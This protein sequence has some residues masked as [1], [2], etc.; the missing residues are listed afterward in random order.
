MHHLK[1]PPL[2]WKVVTNC[3]SIKRHTGLPL[4]PSLGYRT[5]EELSTAWTK[6]VKKASEVKL[7]EET[8]GGRT[9]IEALAACK[10]LDA[11]LYVVSAGLGL[12]HAKDAIPNYNL[13]VSKGDGSILSWLAE[14][15][16]SSM[17]WW[18]A[19]NQKMGK[20][21][22][23]FRLAQI[24]DGVILAM[25]S[26]Y[27]EMISCEL[28]ML[29]REIRERIIIITSCAGQKRLHANLRDRCL[30]YDERLDGVP[31]YKGTRN[32]FPQRALKHLVNEVDFQNMPIETMQR[33]VIEYLDAYS[34]PVLPKR[35]RLDDEQITELLLINWEKYQG[36]R[37]A[38][39][40]FLR[41]VALVACEQKRFGNLWKLAKVRLM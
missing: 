41:D 30:P 4:T 40:R 3:S 36:H 18:D 26:T 1:T 37:E 20:E 28:L 17:E 25:P 31:G 5:L 24:S 39:H 21:L 35:T 8:Y 13:T 12:V 11:S 27:L 22:P 38:L 16:K 6:K 32:D 2:G 14:R 7:V 33:K 15:S 9:F 34:K 10:K 23:I 19:V 29:S